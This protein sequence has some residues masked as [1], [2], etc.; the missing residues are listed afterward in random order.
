MYLDHWMSWYYGSSKTTSVACLSINPRRS[1]LVFI[2]NFAG[3][4]KG[5]Y[6]DFIKRQSQL[7]QLP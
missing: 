7:R 1:A 4:G 6:G 2:F 3:P 5:T